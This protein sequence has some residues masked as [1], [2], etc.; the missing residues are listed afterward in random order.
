MQ[1]QGQWFPGYVALASP[2]SWNSLMVYPG[3]V[4]GVPTIPVYRE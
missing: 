2:T 3:E 1:K 4:M